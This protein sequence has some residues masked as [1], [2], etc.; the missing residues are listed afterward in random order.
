V[1]GD[2]KRVVICS[3]NDAF[4]MALRL[5]FDGTEVDVSKDP[6]RMD[7]PPD[8]LIWRLD[9]DLPGDVL[10]GISEL[11]PTLVL[12]PADQLMTAIDAGC[13]GFLNADASLDEIVGAARTVADGGAVIPSDLLGTVLHHLVERRRQRRPHVDLS[14]LTDRETEVFD[15]A[16]E[17]L[18]KEEI[19]ERLYI[20][21]ATVRTHLQR[22]YRKLSIHS[23]AELMSLAVH[24]DVETKKD[25]NE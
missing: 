14:S 24:G 4:N 13:R 15:L 9:G 5:M 17:G 19:A 22:V 7:V 6:T 3:D 11:T 10:R 25:T 16:A 21:P 12:A 8:V 1:G 23:Q 20:S 2:R 18:R